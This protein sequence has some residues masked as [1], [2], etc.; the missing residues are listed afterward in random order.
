MGE[1]L[2]T[3][4]ESKIVEYEIREIKRKGEFEEAHKKIQR[5]RKKHLKYFRKMS[6]E[7]KL[8]YMRWVRDFLRDYREHKERQIRKFN[9]EIRKLGTVIQTMSDAIE[10]KDIDKFITFWF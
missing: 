8:N 4:I 6:I 5:E 3:S 9:S 2:G 10:E 1:I 7:E